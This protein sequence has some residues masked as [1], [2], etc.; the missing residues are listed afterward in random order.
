M[1]PDLRCRGVNEAL[2]AGATHILTLDSDMVFPNDTLLRLMSHKKPIVGVNYCTKSLDLPQSTAVMEGGRRLSPLI[3]DE[4]IPVQH[5]GFGVCLFEASVFADL[6]KPFFKF[7][8]MGETICGEDY[9]FFTRLYKKKGIRP[10]IDQ[11]LS[12]SCMHIGTFEYEYQ[13]AAS[14]EVFKQRQR[15]IEEQQNVVLSR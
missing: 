8:Y 4:L 13:Y 6:E 5:L 1:L 15:E 3:E 7:S 2:E 12:H 10:F 11:K 14:V 9:Y